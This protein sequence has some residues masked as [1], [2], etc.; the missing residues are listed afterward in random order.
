MANLEFFDALYVAGF[1]KNDLPL[2]RLL[3]ANYPLSA[4]E[5]ASLADFVEGKIK[6]QRGRK[7]W[8]ATDE[9]TDPD[10][11][12]VRRGAYFFEIFLTAD[13]AARNP[14]EGRQKRAIRKAFEYMEKKGCR[15][16]DENRLVNFLRR[17]KQP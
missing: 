3:R 14:A 16:P 1:E 8:K 6:P 7:P 10:G 4:Q 12:A 11:A 15:I 17:S 13:K 5:K 9:L 2:S